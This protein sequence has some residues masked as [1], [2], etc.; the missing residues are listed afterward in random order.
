LAAVL[1]RWALPLGAYVVAYLAYRQTQ[2]HIEMP[3]KLSAEVMSLRHEV[4][5]LSDVVARHQKRDANAA[6]NEAKSRDR[7]VAHQEAENAV[8][9][10][11]AAIE[12]DPRLLLKRFGRSAVLDAIPSGPPA[13]DNHGGPGE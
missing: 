6:G 1:F 4:A 11:A 3:A 2:H 13:G 5:V 8:K 9:A 12:T 10:E 7:A